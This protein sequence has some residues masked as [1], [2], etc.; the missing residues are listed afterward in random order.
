MDGSHKLITQSCA[1]ASAG[2]AVAA[3]AAYSECANQMFHFWNTALSGLGEPTEAVP[4]PPAKPVEPE[5]PFG[6]ALSD[7]NPWGWFDP[8]RLEA[9]WRLTPMTPP[10]QAFMAFADTLPMRGN[11]ASRGM[12]KLM[13]DSGVPR[14]VAWPAAEANAAALA[15]ADTASNGFRSVVASYQTESGY[16][17]AVRGMTPTM[18]A[19]ALTMGSNMV[20]G[21]LF[22]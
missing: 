1:E 5:L 10:A 14:S 3:L 16:A 21:R 11:T 22:S 6:F 7:W 13:I 18:V 9:L 15:A 8:R 17:T 19:V 12:A 4:V 20:P 2:Y